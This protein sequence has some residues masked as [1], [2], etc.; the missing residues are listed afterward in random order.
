MNKIWKENRGAASIV[1]YSIVLPLCLIVFMFLFL[2]GYFLCER[3]VLD[4]AAHRA[5]LVTQKLYS[6]ARFKQIS[7]LDFEDETDYVGYKRNSSEIS[8]TVNEPYRYFIGRGSLTDLAIDTMEKKAISC[9][10]KNRLFPLGDKVGNLKAD[11]DFH[12]GILIQTATVTITEEFTLPELVKLIGLDTKYEMK[13]TAKTSVSDISELINNIDFV[14]EI[15]EDLGA[16]KYFE[17]LQ[18]IFK[19]IGNFVKS[20][21]GDE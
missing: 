15:M 2:A 17:Q 21:G 6:D 4:A 10:E 7:D 9:V 16:D 14:M 11:A 19:K 12:N 3:A 5:V 18:D 20:L 13:V 8:E 1:E